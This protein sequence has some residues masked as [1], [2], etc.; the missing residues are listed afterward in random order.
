MFP[1]T[2]LYGERAGMPLLAHSFI[3]N[4]VEIPRTVLYG[5]ANQYSTIILQIP[6]I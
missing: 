3:G 5:E 4:T 6:F 1:R 2:V